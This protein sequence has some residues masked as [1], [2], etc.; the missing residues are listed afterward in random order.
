MLP[1]LISRPSRAN[2]VAEA[3]ELLDRVG[4]AHRAR[5]R[6]DHLSG[7][8]QQRVAIARA[9]TGE[10]SLVLADEPTGNLDTKSGELVLTLMHELCKE[11]G[12]AVVLVTHDRDVLN[13]ADRSVTMRDGRLNADNRAGSAEAEIEQAPA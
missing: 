6:A 7:G 8:E 10:P 2:V 1:R 5:H 11:R 9:L 4:L 3:N 12:A 13:Y